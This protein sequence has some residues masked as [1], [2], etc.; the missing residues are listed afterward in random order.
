MRGEG[1]EPRMRPHSNALKPDSIE[2]GE[3]GKLKALVLITK[4]R[5][6]IQGI[7]GVPYPGLG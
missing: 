4:R 3:G 6:S 5:G 7:V 2:G 1:K